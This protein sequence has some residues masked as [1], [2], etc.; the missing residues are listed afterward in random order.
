MYGV[1][2]AIGC[3][4]EG[5]Q[6][7]SLAEFLSGKT[8]TRTIQTDEACISITY[9]RY[10]RS[11]CVAWQTGWMRDLK[12]EI[13]GPVFLTSNKQ[14]T[15]EMLSRNLQNDATSVNTYISSLQTNYPHEWV[16]MNNVR[17]YDHENKRQR[18]AM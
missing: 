13:Y 17:S 12:Y 10:G 2:K 11:P 7:E 1:W 15:F 4:E 16:I 8:T 5:N 3:W 9:Q 6:I 18:F 14:I